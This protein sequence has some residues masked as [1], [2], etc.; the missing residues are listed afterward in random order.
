MA[1]SPRSVRLPEP[2]DEGVRALA[3]QTGR[4]FSS[5]MSELLEEGLRMRRIPGI[6]FT[7]GYRG[8]MA[9]VAGTGI[10]VWEVVRDY[11]DMDA[12]W[13]DLREAYHWLNETQLRAALAYAEAYPTEIDERIRID[14]EWTPE[15][16]YATYPFMRPP[17]A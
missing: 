16:L 1:R 12:C 6:D 5:V 2:V 13:D 14:E 4:P 17:W 15:K 10:Q 9:K 8:R 7:D 11:R 3:K